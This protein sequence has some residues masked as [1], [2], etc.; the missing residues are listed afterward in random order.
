MNKK[1]QELLFLLLKYSSNETLNS[2]YSLININ[3]K[4]LI[5]IPNFDVS[6]S[7][8]SLLLNSPQDRKAKQI[9]L[10]LTII[11]RAIDS[12]NF[13]A[14]NKQN[15]HDIESLIELA[16]KTKKVLFWN[17]RTVSYYD[18]NDILNM[19]ENIKQCKIKTTKYNILINNTKVENIRQITNKN[20]INRFL[21]VYESLATAI[22]KNIKYCPWCNPDEK[23]KQSKRPRKQDECRDISDFIVY[24]GKYNEKYLN[25]HICHIKGVNIQE[26]RTLRGRELISILS[27]INANCKGNDT[28]FK[29]SFTEILKMVERRY[30]VK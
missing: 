25:D 21:T 15:I 2:I 24:Y 27:N 4:T 10:F 26:T 12:T 23:I 17:S 5:P 20:K 9:E 30:G 18:I 22:D 1:Y 14:V 13:L 19:Q 29:K 28:E 8:F 7:I 16:I 11:C 3:R 6:Y